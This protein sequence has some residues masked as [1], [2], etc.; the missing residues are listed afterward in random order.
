[1]TTKKEQAAMPMT[2]QKQN[3]TAQVYLNTAHRARVNQIKDKLS[4]RVSW[5]GEIT[6]ILFY[7]QG[8]HLNQR[9]RLLGWRLL[10]STLRSYCALSGNPSQS[11][12]EGTESTFKD[13]SGF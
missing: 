2:A 4:L 3:S 13:E 1:M 7:L 8:P 10:R 6:H 12:E 5:A 11:D 9:E